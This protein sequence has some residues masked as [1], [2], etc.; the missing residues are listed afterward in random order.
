MA[1][2]KTR[3][4]IVPTSLLLSL[5]VPSLLSHVAARDLHAT[6]RR[7]DHHRGYPQPLLLF[8]IAHFARLCAFTSHLSVISNAVRVRINDHVLTCLGKSSTYITYL[9]ITSLLVALPTRPCFI[10]ICA[11][12]LLSSSSL[13]WEYH[14]IT[15]DQ[16]NQQ[17]LNPP[18]GY[19][20]PSFERPIL[21]SIPVPSDSSRHLPSPTPPSPTY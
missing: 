15:V 20:V 5:L 21:R 3:C 14:L 1:F 4:R 17:N 18:L 9:A 16:I 6:Q 13:A 7:L 8:S 12:Q 2:G 10:S 19:S 11:T